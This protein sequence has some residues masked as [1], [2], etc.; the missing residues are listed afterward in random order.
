MPLFEI[1]T[2]EHLERFYHIEA[3]TADEARTRFDNMDWDDQQA[4]ITWESE[5]PEEEM[6]SIYPL[7]EEEAL[8]S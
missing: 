2:M 4:L 1:V 6:I 5:L 7:D 3:E 8:A